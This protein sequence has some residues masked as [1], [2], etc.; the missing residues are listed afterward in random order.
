[1]NLNNIPTVVENEM[2]LIII[3]KFANTIRIVDKT[4]MY[5]F[6]FLTKLI[7]TLF[8][9]VNKIIVNLPA[10]FGISII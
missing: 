6:I 9:R 3:F 10:A 1:M 5:I 2:F 7:K 4:K 8:E